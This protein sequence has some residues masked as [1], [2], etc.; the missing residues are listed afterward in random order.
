MRGGKELLLLV[1][2]ALLA[3]C[4]SVSG[5]IS[6]SSPDENSPTWTTRVASFFS[7]AKPGV[8]QPASPVASAP[9]VECP[10]VDIRNGASTLNITAKADAA[11]VG[12]SAG[13]DR[14]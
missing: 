2:G 5:V 1:A 4:S 14:R 13:T 9:Q 11:T 8:S 12:H 3:G 10:G 7:G 6:S